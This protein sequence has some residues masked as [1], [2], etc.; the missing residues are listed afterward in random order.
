MTDY[1]T[2]LAARAFTL[3][4][5]ASALYDFDVMGVDPLTGIIELLHNKRQWRLTLER[6]P[7]SFVPICA[8]HGSDQCTAL[9]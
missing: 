1:S 9:L 6:V 7:E 3:G 2:D 8:C 5:L 4:N